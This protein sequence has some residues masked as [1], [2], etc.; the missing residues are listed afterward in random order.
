LLPIF[1]ALGC[2]LVA[3]PALFAWCY[4]SGSFTPWAREEPYFQ[5]DPAKSASV[6]GLYFR[7]HPA[8]SARAGDP[9]PDMDVNCPP[10]RY[11]KILKGAAANL[12]DGLDVIGVAIGGKHRAYLVR[13]LA[14]VN[15]HVVNDMVDTTPVTITFC[16]RLGSAKVFTA[17]SR[18]APLSVSVAGW[19][20]I[21]PEGGGLVLKANG[22]RYLQNSG[23]AVDSPGAAGF[24]YPELPFTRTKWEVW[25]KAHPDT[26]LYLGNER[27]FSPQ[28]AFV[29]P[30]TLWPPALR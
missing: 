24:P 19:R 30:Q 18:G 21:R 8:K 23:K 3:G 29:P 11:P 28:G 6:G 5:H 2:L 15:G 16:S 9:F 20:K 7:H 25:K 12:P 26:D 14:P 1:L 4:L 13:A 27:L 22:K 10:L 17:K